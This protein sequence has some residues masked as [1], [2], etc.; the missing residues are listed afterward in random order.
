M[1]VFRDACAVMVTA[2]LLTAYRIRPGYQRVTQ[3]AHKGSA[4]AAHGQEKQA[5]GRERT[6]REDNVLIKVRQTQRQVSK[7]S[8]FLSKS[9]EGSEYENVTGRERRVR[10]VDGIKA[11]L[12]RNF[13]ATHE[14]I[15][16]ICT[17]IIVNSRN[18]GSSR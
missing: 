9:A 1:S 5:V 3:C 11:H 10:R 2:A 6:D 17:I 7:V 8:R 14:C 4:A 18:M 12:Y 15:Q 13:T 16:Y